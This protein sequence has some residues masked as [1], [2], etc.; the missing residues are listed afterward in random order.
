MNFI[1]AK[2]YIIGHL[3]E[4]LSQDLYFHSFEHSLDVLHSAT[5]LN[6]MEKMDEKESVLIETAAIYHDAGMIRTYM[7]H[8]LES[9]KLAREVL[10]LF[11]YTPEEI[12]QVESLI[13]V[14]TM[15]QFAKTKPEMVLCDADLD[16]LGREDFFISSFQLQLEWKIFG[17]MD[18]TLAEWIRF[19]IDFMEKHQYFT[20]SAIKLRDGQK[21]KNIQTFKDLLK[22]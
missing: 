19:E 12:E 5:L 4:G 11:D 18:T 14:T 7:N 8:E 3:Q 1:G 9:A 2:N 21:Q 20:P 16:V 15:P 10:P 13:M 6:R 22:I 17:V